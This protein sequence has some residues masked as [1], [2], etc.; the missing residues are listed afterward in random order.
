[1]IERFLRSG[2][3]GF[4]FSVVEEGEV[5]AGDEFEFLARRDAESDDR[6]GRTTFTFRKLP[7]RSCCSG[8]SQVQSLPESWRERCRREVDACGESRQI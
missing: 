2:Y 4:Y 5:G 8:R 3:S 7:T 6:R 1:M